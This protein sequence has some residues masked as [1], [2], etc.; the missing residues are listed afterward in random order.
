MDHQ[1][2]QHQDMLCFV[3]SADHAADQGFGEIHGDGEKRTVQEKEGEER[4]G[5]CDHNEVRGEKVPRTTR[6]IMSFCS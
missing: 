6:N 4:K 3:E 5:D 1:G 2:I